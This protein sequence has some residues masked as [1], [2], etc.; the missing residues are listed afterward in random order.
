M[1]N[2]VNVK[3]LLIDDDPATNIIHSEIIQS[4]FP[5]IPIEVIEDSNLAIE[6]LG[7]L[8]RKTDFPEKWIIFLDLNMPGY[9]GWDVLEKVSWNKYAEKIQNDI[10][11]H[12]LTTSR[13]PKEREVGANVK[14]LKGVL[15]KPLT[16]EM[17]S[18]FIS[19]V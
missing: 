6:K 7:R 16:S 18:N 4:S 15:R 1:T 8:I 17:V 19:L 3:V 5:H 9:N 13:D 12:I 2:Y 14:H 11:L 10:S